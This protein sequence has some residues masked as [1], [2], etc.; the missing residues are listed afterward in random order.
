MTRA[1]TGGIDRMIPG[2]PAGR[3]AGPNGRRRMPKPLESSG[4]GRASRRHPVTRVYRARSTLCP[5]RGVGRRFLDRD[6]VLSAW[7]AEPR[8]QLRHAF[9]GPQRDALSAPAA[10][11]GDKPL[12][13]YHARQWIMGLRCHN[14]P[15]AGTHGP[16]RR[17]ARRPSPPMPCGSPPAALVI[18]S[19]HGGFQP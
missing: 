11:A 15:P 8:M 14:V 9:R 3:R 10:G 13:P 17:P 2:R 1:R 5:G 12:R 7:H 16:A 4:E 18:S 6:G 19:T